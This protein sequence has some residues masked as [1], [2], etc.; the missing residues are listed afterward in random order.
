MFLFALMLAA[1]D[2]P[3]SPMTV[4]RFQDAIT[5]QVS[6]Q[7]VLREGD[8]RLV[9]SCDRPG[10]DIKVSV[11]TG[12]WLVRAPLFYG[13]RNFIYRFDRERAQR[14]LWVPGDRSASLVARRRVIPFLQA[15]AVSNHVV[16]RM[17]DVEDRW[18]DTTF[19]LVEVRPAL[20][21]LF[22]ACQRADLSERVLNAA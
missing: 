12:R 14:R 21:Q 5:D 11:F 1:M 7:A 16:I 8:R 17:R 10:G 15:M 19:R 4:E 3:A 13:H 18:F 2:L 22:A 20:G 9:I 6:A